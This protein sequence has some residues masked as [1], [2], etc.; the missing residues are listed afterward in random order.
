MIRVSIGRGILRIGIIDPGLGI[1]GLRFGA[2]R[3][4]PGLYPPEVW[5]VDIPDIKVLDFFIGAL[6][7]DIAAWL[8]FACEVSARQGQPFR[9]SRQGDPVGASDNPNA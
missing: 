2:S 4:W 9:D 5:R 3:R 8:C 7:L 6:H 1:C